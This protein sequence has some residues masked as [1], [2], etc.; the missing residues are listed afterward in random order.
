M[1]NSNNVNA[2]DDD[3]DELLL[4]PA[5]QESA[6][7]NSSRPDWYIPNWAP[8]SSNVVCALLVFSSCITSTVRLHVR[9]FN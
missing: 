8:R 9:I 3:H 1:R 7:M 6:D 4:A 5:C 2:L